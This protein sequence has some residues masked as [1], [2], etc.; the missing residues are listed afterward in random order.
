LVTVYVHKVVTGWG[1]LNIAGT[2][3]GLCGLSL[4]ESHSRFL[5]CLIMKGYD[6][7]PGVNDII[8]DAYRQLDEYFA[9]VRKEFRLPLDLKGTS[10]QLRIWEAVGRIPYGEVWSYQM[11]AEEAGYPRAYRAA[12]NAIGENPVA[13]VI[14]CHRV[15]RSD[16]T[17][18]GYGGREYLKKRLLTLEGSISK[19]KNMG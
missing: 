4:I 5:K 10:F 15:V 9:G 1:P 3:D 7:R 16:G 14:P 11:V 8:V 6:V 19:I 13:I 18:G 17:L 12:G 2:A